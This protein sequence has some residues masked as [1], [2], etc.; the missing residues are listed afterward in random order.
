MVLDERQGVHCVAIKFEGRRAGGGGGGGGVEVGD[1]LEFMLKRAPPSETTI[2]DDLI[3][4]M[5]SVVEVE[6]GTSQEDRV[7]AALWMLRGQ[8]ENVL[9]AYYGQEQDSWLRGEIDP[10]VRS[11]MRSL[12]A[13][14]SG[15]LESAVRVL[16]ENLSVLDKNLEE[17]IPNETRRVAAASGRRIKQ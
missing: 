7:V 2:P 11:L 17:H 9:E 14:E 16:D 12:R 8:L 6:S 1:G 3:Q 15:V 13:Q 4:L 10:H 5:L